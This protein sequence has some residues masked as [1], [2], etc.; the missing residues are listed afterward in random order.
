MKP[1]LTIPPYPPEIIAAYIAQ[2]AAEPG[3]DRQITAAAVGRAFG[4]M[5]PNQ[6][7]GL[8]EVHDRLHGAA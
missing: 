2:R 7:L 4:M 6:V 3:V 1:D 5:P 8:V